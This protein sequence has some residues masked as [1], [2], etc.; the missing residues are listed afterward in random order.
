M[1][2]AVIAV[3]GFLVIISLL[4]TTDRFNQRFSGRSTRSPGSGRRRSGGSDGFG[5]SL[6]GGFGS[7]A[8]GGG[9]GGGCGGDGGGGDGGGGC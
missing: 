3:A 6:F 5:G 7:G 8:S 9:D 2:V 4:A 1:T